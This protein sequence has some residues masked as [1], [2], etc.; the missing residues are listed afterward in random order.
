MKCGEGRFLICVLHVFVY[1]PEGSSG[2]AGCW[3]CA[4][5]GGFPP[6]AGWLRSE[7]CR[8]PGRRRTVFENQKVRNFLERYFLPA[9]VPL[10]SL[11]FEGGHYF[12]PSNVWEV[13]YSPGTL[14]K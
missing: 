1:D 6:T 2:A 11:L 3:L 9:I 10:P 4:F 7:S 5:S 8:D 13:W 12:E 14:G